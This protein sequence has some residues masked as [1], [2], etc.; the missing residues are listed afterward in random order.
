MKPTILIQSRI[1]QQSMPAF[2][3]AFAP[4]IIFKRAIASLQ[5]ALEHIIW[6]ELIHGETTDNN[7]FQTITFIAFCVFCL[8]AYFADN[9]FIPLLVINVALCWWERWLAKQVYHNSKGAIATLEKLGNN[10]QWQLAYPNGENLRQRFKIE[11]LAAIE[12]RRTQVY[13]GLSGE[14][15]ALVWQIDLQLADQNLIPI[16]TEFNLET[17]IAKVRSLSQE[18]Q[19]PFTFTKSEPLP[20]DPSLLNSSVTYRSTTQGWQI[21]TGWTIA[22]NWKLIGKVFDRAGFLLFAIILAGFATKFGDF[23]VRLFVAWRE[24]GIILLDM[25][26]LFQLLN[27]YTIFNG[28]GLLIAIGMMVWEGGRLSMVKQLIGDRHKLQLK[29]AQYQVASISQPVEGIVFLP[30]PTPLLAI[31]D[32]KNQVI[33]ITDLPRLDDYRK[34]GFQVSQTLLN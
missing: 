19:I 13:V 16:A 8:L 15:I 11:Q 9:F 10:Y 5:S 2:A 31:W 30:Q 14:P 22:D 29:I 25:S 20:T 12:I 3:I 17:A 21:K 24:E 23:L 4:F 28:L 6:A 32:N 7:L 1:P 27:N 18:L 33:E 26:P 34:I